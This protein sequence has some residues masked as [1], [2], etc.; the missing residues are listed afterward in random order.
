MPRTSEVAF[1][2]LF[3][4]ALRGK[5]PLWRDHLRVEQS[6]VF[7]GSPKL[8]PDLL[9]QGPDTQRVGERTNRMALTIIAYALAVHAAIAGRRDIPPIPLLRTESRTFFQFGVLDAWNLILRD[10]NY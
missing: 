8:R 5:H 10:I 2:S 9:V 3:A 4:E 7:P 1:N 6:G